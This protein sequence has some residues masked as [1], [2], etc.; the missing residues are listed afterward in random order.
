M[1]SRVIYPRDAVD[2]FSVESVLE[3]IVQVPPVLPVGGDAYLARDLLPLREGAR[4]NK[5]ALVGQVTLT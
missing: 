2:G 1:C 4:V 3:A 5:G